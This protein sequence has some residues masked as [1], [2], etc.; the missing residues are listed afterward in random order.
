MQFT[1][2]NVNRERQKL[3]RLLEPAWKSLDEVNEVLR[4]IQA[5][6]NDIDLEM[7][8]ALIEERLTFADASC[9]DLLQYLSIILVE[10]ACFLSS[11]TVKN[12]SYDGS[13]DTLKKIRE[14]LGKIQAVS[15]ILPHSNIY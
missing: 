7:T 2:L 1:Q 10:V 13:I 15:K 14:S 9:E 6:V 4:E 3:R 12:E 8:V 5:E 11:I